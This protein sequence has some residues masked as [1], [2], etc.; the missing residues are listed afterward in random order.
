MSLLKTAQLALGLLV[1]AASPCMASNASCDDAKALLAKAVAFYKAEGQEKSIAKF[2][3]KDGGYID[4]DLYV[5][6]MDKNGI[7]LSHAAKPALL[8]KSGM[9]LKDADGKAFVED[10]YKIKDKGEVS[11]RWAN[12]TTNVVSTKVSYMERIGDQN[13]IGVGCYKE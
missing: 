9:A 11:Y 3:E 2:M 7:F 8:G 1:V 5:F 6:L 4:R 13:I 12:P 10:F